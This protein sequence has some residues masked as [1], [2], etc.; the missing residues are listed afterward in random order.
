MAFV[1]TSQQE[2]QQQNQQNNQQTG[3]PVTL[4]EGVG[5]SPDAKGGSGTGTTS[6]ATP[7]AKGSPSASSTFTNLQAYLD[8]NQSGANTLAGKVATGVSNDITGAAN[9]ITDQGNQFASGVN[10]GTVNYDPNL[11]SSAVNDA[12]DFINNQS[13]MAQLAAQRAGQYSGPSAWENSSNATTAQT[14]AQQAQQTAAL[15][16][17][18]GG[19]EQLITQDNSD[20]YTQGGLSLNQYLIQ[21]TPGALSQVTN[22]A[23]PAGDLTNQFNT[24]QT[25]SDNAVQGA[26]D[27]ST[28]T[29]TKTNQALSG[30][31]NDYRTQIDQAVSGATTAQQQQF[32]N[33]T[34]ALTPTSTG[35]AQPAV[36][37]ATPA[38][39]YNVTDD[40]LSQIGVTRDQW[41]QLVQLNNQAISE[42]NAGVNLSNYLTNTP[43]QY[44]ESSVATPQQQ[45]Y[46][47]ALNQLAGTGQTLN[48]GGTAGGSAYDL[49]GAYNALLA[50][51]QAKAPTGGLTPTGSNSSGSNT[52]S[53]IGAGAG[54]AGI[55]NQIGNLL[56]PKPTDSGPN[57]QQASQQQQQDA[58]NV[59][60]NTSP[61]PV[62]PEAP[63]VAVQ[64]P[65]TEPQGNISIENP[66]TGQ[67]YTSTATAPATS[68]TTA[69]STPQGTVTVEPVSG[70]ATAPVVAGAAGA[71]AAGSALGALGSTLPTGVITVGDAAAPA[72]AA[73]SSLAPE[74]ADVGTGAAGA[75][76]ASAVGAIDAAN[77]GATAA[78]AAAPV[79]GT[80]GAAL[81]VLGAVM[82]AVDPPP[83]VELS[84]KYWTSVT[85]ALQQAINSGDKGAIA[86]Q[87]N[88]L[89]GQPQN[90][91][92]VNIQKLVYSTGMVPSMGWGQ[93]YVPNQF[94][95]ASQ[96]LQQ[97][98]T[99]ALNNKGTGRK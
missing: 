83:T 36:A 89:L 49:S 74:L 43:G 62:I 55:I 66:D 53:N 4:S 16:G 65:Q 60:N 15:T 29:A 21:N 97:I 52:A 34:N 33:L 39:S 84:G 73:G 70:T 94:A 91:I 82:L 18:T 20:P 25:N 11:V 44:T 88:G 37:G 35:T 71:T 75:E 98:N 50:Q 92:P 45:A 24:T 7:S 27:T 40:Q 3:G 64:P 5:A 56:K 95:L 86:A 72:L 85:N 90:T 79:L 28:A 87:V 1:D 51:L 76:A 31:V 93:Q 30:A 67:V 9:T 58:Q 26:K 6:V 61:A 12:T 80:A 23:V 46:F 48:S 81:A 17:T 63:P 14:A 47:A 13:S 41:N 10:A 32:T 19:R 2:D 96:L 42:G 57:T 59:I 22:S 38:P 78:E 77:G 99:S 54:L 69:P 68:T 8:A